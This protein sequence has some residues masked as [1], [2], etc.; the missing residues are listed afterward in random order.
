MHN[1]DIRG[2]SPLLFLPRRPLSF[3]CTAL[4][5][6]GP[7]YSTM[8]PNG[9]AIGTNSYKIALIR[10]PFRYTRHPNPLGALLFYWLCGGLSP[11]G[12]A[13]SS[14][15]RCAP[16]FTLVVVVYRSPE[17]AVAASAFR[18]DIYTRCP[19]CRLQLAACVHLRLL[20]RRATS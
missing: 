19:R 18:Q 20:T 6:A 17:V 7:S 9:S 14:S 2:P 15:L 4:S 5:D 13:P 1:D 12:S 8:S 10:F 16:C 11:D 3:S